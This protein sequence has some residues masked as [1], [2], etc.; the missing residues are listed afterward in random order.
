MKAIIPFCLVLF[1]FQSMEVRAA[2][3]SYP[4]SYERMEKDVFALQERYGGLQVG[5][6]GRSERGK[7]LWYVKIGKGREEILL[8]GSHHGREWI[9]SRFLMKLL[10]EYAE[11]YEAGRSISG[12]PAHLLDEI[13]LVFIPMLN[14]DG[15]AI[16]QKGIQGRPFLERWK[17]LHMNGYHPDF[18][19][20]K[21]NGEGIDLNRQYPA[22]WDELKKLPAWPFYK[23]Y[24]GK[25]PVQ[26]AEVKA[27]VDFTFRHEPSLALTYHT[28]GRQ[29]F[30][31]YRTDSKYIERDYRLA[32]QI[33]DSTGYEVDMPDQGAVGGGYT[34]WFITTFQKP[35]F[36]IEMCE[37]VEET[38][39]PA[40]CL[41]KEWQGNKRVP[42]MLVHELLQARGADER[43]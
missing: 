34:D 35:A 7:E 29:V 39:P 14:P 8:V 2:G 36:T 16:Q 26:A 37:L 22:G 19:R 13:A 43:P 28:S 32:E 18:A 42:L 9:T 31:Y 30:W 17:L 24:R 40:A 3:S 23:Q 38:N 27:L 4:Y 11:A 21:A 15:V 20:W 5:S 1:L 41:A 25:K 6:I 10:K 12:Y 33:A